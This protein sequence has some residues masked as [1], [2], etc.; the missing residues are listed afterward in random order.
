MDLFEAASERNLD[1]VPLAERLRPARIGDV[2]GQRHLV[3]EGSF[4]RRALAVGRLPS[5]LLWGPPGTGK[6][7]LA[8]VLSHEVDARF[9]RMSAVLA[10][11][12]DVRQAVD[13]AKRARHEHRKKTLLFLDEIH[14]F[15]KAQQDALLPHVE[16][17][18]VTLIGATTENPSFEVNAAL[19]SRC[20]VLT[21]K[22]LDEDDQKKLLLRAMETPDKGLGH[23]PVVLDDDAAN[24]LVGASSGD[25]RRLLLSLEVAADLALADR[26][27]GEDAVVTTAHVEQAVARRLVRFDKRG[28]AHYGVISCFIKSMR[29]SDPDAALYYLAHMLEAG[30]D[31]MFILRRLVIFASEDVGMADPRSLEVATAAVQ[32]FQLLGLPEGQWALAQATVHLASAPKSNASYKGL[33]AARAAVQQNPNA[34]LPLHLQNAPTKLMANEGFGKGYR[35][36]HDVGGFADGVQYLPDDFVDTQFYVPTQNGAEAAFARHLRRL[37]GTGRYP[38]PSSEE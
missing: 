19:L 23:L 18:T 7:T 4:L 2:V 5:L 27:A 25:A 15:N 6:T 37:W 31:P 38:D 21:T 11:V 30:E 36:P 12:K 24:A 28:D 13:D 16:N 14:R 1:G 32:A 20:R 9:V 8:E 35:Y 29:G 33:K 10:G 26:T 22:P 17:G 34:E 3:G